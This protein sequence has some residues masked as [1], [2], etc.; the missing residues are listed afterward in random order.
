MLIASL[1][2]L[3]D[4]LARKGNVLPD[5]Y[6]SVGISYVVNLAPDGQVDSITDWRTPPAENKKGKPLPKESLFPRR[7][8]KTAICS[9]FIEHRPL[10]I[11]GL[12]YDNK[13]G[14][15]DASSNKAQK[16]HA[17]F[18]ET[19]LPPLRGVSHPLVDGFR[20]F[21]ESW[22]PASQLS[23]PLLLGLGKELNTAGFAFGLSGHPELLLH[24]CEPI[25]ETW[26]AMVAS[27]PDEALSV[28][29]CAILGDILPIARIH[30][31]AKG[32]PGGASTGNTLISYK[33]SAVES[34]GRSQSFNSNVSALA[35]KKYT[36][37]LNYLIKERIHRMTIDGLLL[38]HWAETGDQRYDSLFD[39]LLSYSEKPDAEETNAALSRLFHALPSGVPGIDTVL[40]EDGLDP[41]T[42]F[43]IMGI[44]P[45]AARLSMKFLYRNRFGHLVDNVLQHQRDMQLRSDTGY[46]P[47]WR[48]RAELVS[49]KSSRDKVDS[50]FMT[51][52]LNSILNALPYPQSL[53]GTVVRRVRTDRDNEK[54][55][56]TKMNPVRMGLIKAFINRQARYRGQ[57]EVIRM[58]LDFENRNPAYLCGRLFFLLEDIQLRS[59]NYALKRTI[60]DSYFSSACA[61]PA[62]VFPHLLKLSQHHMAKLDSARFAD[63]ELSDL[64][65]QL[66]SSFPTVLDLT[67]QGIFILGYYQ[68]KAYKAEQIRRHKEETAV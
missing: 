16:S 65:Q 31:K 4:C 48:I 6:S 33:N 3:Y 42:T 7:T 8:Q 22:D 9:N 11:F 30:D 23:N 62:V 63:A 39:S 14:T 50:A 10:Y 20:H 68:Q 18:V 49:P 15:L 17:A 35:M 56:D 58:A 51:S 19:N 52:L 2:S 37:A 21:L 54:R 12:A 60:R 28:A 26:Q 44:E 34:Y 40:F 32:I 55:Q 57:E 5:G 67:D 25:R 27:E 47:M 13:T 66:G 53:L 29:Q 43:Y 36:E 1:C 46:I 41:S 59:T 24:E 45:N 61:R 38:L 64:M